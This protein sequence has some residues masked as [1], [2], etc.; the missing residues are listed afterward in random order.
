MKKLRVINNTRKIILVE[1]GQLADSWFPRLIGLMGRR[2]FEAGDGLW[3]AGEKAI[4]SFG[5]LV[6]IDV[7]YLDARGLI[8]RADAGMAPW[9]MGLLVRG[10]NDVL[11]LPIGTIARTGTRCGDHISYEAIE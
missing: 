3:L 5:M 7:L 8:L 6:P 4:H 11:E 10:V 9:R 1:R 2:S